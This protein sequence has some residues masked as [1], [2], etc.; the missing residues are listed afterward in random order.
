MLMEVMME[1]GDA[2]A[3][4]GENRCDVVVIVVVVVM[5]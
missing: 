5:K 4:V 3:G 1:G 2:G